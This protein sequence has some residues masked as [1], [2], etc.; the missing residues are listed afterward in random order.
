MIAINDRR[1]WD[2]IIPASCGG[3]IQV[4]CCSWCNNLKGDRSLTEWL[5]SEALSQRVWD[6]GGREKDAEPMNERILYQLRDEDLTRIRAI[7]EYHSEK[8]RDGF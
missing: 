4:P 8:V 1:T 6:V 7:I 3:K 5:Q 2:H